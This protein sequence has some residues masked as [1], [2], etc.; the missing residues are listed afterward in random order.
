[1]TEVNKFK[2]CHSLRLFFIYHHFYIADGFPTIA[3]ASMWTRTGTS[4]FKQTVRNAAG[5]GGVLQ[6]G[7][8]E[9][10][11]IRVPTHVQGRCLFWEFA[12]DNFDI[13]MF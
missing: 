8:G 3:S 1:M 2:N 7:H 9:T 10:V 11:T 5:G 6:V 12:T 13:G 4:Q